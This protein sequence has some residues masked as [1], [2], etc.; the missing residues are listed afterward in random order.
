MKKT[1]KEELLRIHEIT[2]GKKL[3]RESFIDDILNKVS[4]KYDKKDIDD[5]K[6][7]DLITDD[8]LDFFKTIED[9]AKSGGLKQQTS[10]EMGY[11]K[12]V[13]SMQI[14]LTL[15]GY[16]LPKYGI[17]GLFGP[18]TGVAVQ[19]FI[20][21]H[22]NNLNEDANLLRTTLD[23]LGYD[24]KGSEITSG[25]NITNEISSIVSNIL[26]DFKQKNPDIKV[27]ITSGND[28]FH[29]RLGYKSKHSEGNAVDIVLNPYTSQSSNDFISILNNY[30]NKDSNFSY[31]DEYK[32]PSPS[33]TGGHFHLQYGGKSTNSSTEIVA[34]PEMLMKLV[35]LL[36]SRGVKSEELKTYIDQQV[37]V[38]GFSNL[39]LN[40]EQGYRS[41]VE[42]CDVFI[43][44]NNPNPL[45]ITGEMMAKGAKTAY[46]RYR[47]YVPPELA[48]SQLVLEGGIR[49]GDLNSRPIR[50]K[51]PFNVGNVDTGANVFYDDV[52]SSI[53]VYY[54]LIAK[55][56]LGK[57]KS[58]QDLL[59]NFVNK[60]GN[61]YATAPNYERILNKL[62]VDVNKISVPIIAKNIKTDLTA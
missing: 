5:P 62:A 39:D 19:K 40:T 58:A 61:R 20:S 13:E 59:N 15:L 53:N 2:Y 41:Y 25:G 24:E 52:Q 32:N 54:N 43:N 8:V 30:K 17:D 21:D 42:I 7:A 49:N 44:N 4:G 48:L 35:E 47:Q 33:S 60:S 6:K 23:N 3:I 18:E 27:I 29:K 10:G 36:K 31:I 46:D 34:S 38:E 22:L 55:S 57:G 26:K 9:A 56:Y 28:N 14:G 45:G 37:S 1:L 16:Q 50:T 51:N 11:Q 12:S